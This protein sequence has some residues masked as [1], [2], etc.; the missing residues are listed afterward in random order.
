MP[1]SQSFSS[2]LNSPQSEADGGMVSAFMHG[3]TPNQ[4]EC[5][6]YIAIASTAD[7]LHSPLHISPAD[8]H[9]DVENERAFVVVI[10]KQKLQETTLLSSKLP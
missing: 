6:R 2:V 7:M 10:H 5:Y 8:F 3:K 9:S 4:P 1:F